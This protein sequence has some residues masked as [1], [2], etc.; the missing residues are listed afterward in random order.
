MVLEGWD[1]RGK[2]TCWGSPFN[3]LVTKMGNV[4]LGW[5]IIRRSPE[6]FGSELGRMCGAL[7][8]LNAPRMLINGNLESA[9]PTNCS[10]AINFIW[11]LLGPDHRRHL[12]ST[13]FRVQFDPLPRNGWRQVQVQ[14][15]VPV[16]QGSSVATPYYCG[17]LVRLEVSAG[18]QNSKRSNL[19]V[20]RAAAS[21]IDC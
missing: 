19:P 6:T 17:F 15:A 13:C 14:L 21:N 16:R 11:S 18:L 2:G 3:L 10:E 1:P 8:T 5:Y 4:S 20:R 12:Q 7:R 9:I